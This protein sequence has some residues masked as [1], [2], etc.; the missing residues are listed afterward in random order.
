MNLFS[1]SF[2]SL[3]SRLVKTFTNCGYLSSLALNGNKY[4][5]GNNGCNPIYQLK[6]GM[7]S[8][9]FVSDSIWQ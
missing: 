5:V 2:S 6:R 4:F 7:T 9:N 3:D 1:C 8:S